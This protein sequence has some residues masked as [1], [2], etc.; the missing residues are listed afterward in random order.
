MNRIHHLRSFL[1]EG[2]RSLFFS[3]HV[4]LFPYSTLKRKW[5][6]PV[7]DELAQH[8]RIPAAGF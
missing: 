8:R 2:L 6:S 7:I 4:L 5:V 3:S 1:F